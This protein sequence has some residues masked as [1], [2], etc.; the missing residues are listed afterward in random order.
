MPE[1]VDVLEPAE[2]GDDVAPEPAGELLVSVVLV[3]LLG[4]DELLEPIEPVEPVD[5]VAPVDAFEPVEPV[6]DA[7][8]LFDP[9][10]PDCCCALVAFSSAA[11]PV[12]PMPPVAA[13][14]PELPTASELPVELVDPVPAALPV[15]PVELPVVLDWPIEPLLLEAGDVDVPVAAVLL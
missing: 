15:V 5:P 14:L 4:A 7:P 13:A 11:V 1:P 9:L 6:L 3:E 8:V 12:D 10:L 2:L